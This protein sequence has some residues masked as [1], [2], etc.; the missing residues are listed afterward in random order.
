MGREGRETPQPCAGGQASVHPR[1][2]HRWGPCALPGRPPLAQG[3]RDEVEQR[4]SCSTAPRAE[5]GRL[6]PSCMCPD[7][8]RAKPVPRVCLASGPPSTGA[9]GS[10]APPLGGKLQAEALA[11]HRGPT[12]GHRAP[13]EFP[14]PSCSWAHGHGPR[15]GLHS[16][17]PWNLWGTSPAPETSA[18]PLLGG[19]AG[20]AWQHLC[21]PQFQA[22]GPD[23]CGAEWGTSRVAGGSCLTQWP[24]LRL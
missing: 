2:L 13:G 7:R 20:R 17:W 14:R 5:L 18:P 23:A 16:G 19:S 1:E 12:T 22:Q 10:P 11:R 15:P 3:A 21:E 9:P 4:P 6:S 8:P 24:E